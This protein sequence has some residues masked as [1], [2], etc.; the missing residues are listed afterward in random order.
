MLETTTKTTEDNVPE[1]TTNSTQSPAVDASTTQHAE[2]TTK[3]EDNVPEVTTNSTESPAVD[4]STTTEQTGNPVNGPDVGPSNGGRSS[5]ANAFLAI[6]IVIVVI[7]CLIVVVRV[8]QKK[9][10]QKA[11]QQP[12][13]SNISSRSA[14]VNGQNNQDF[15]NPI[16]FP[17]FKYDDDI[18]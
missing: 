12:Q 14:P 10:R 7:I 1:V 2:T 3:T 4:A 18:L 16:S 17:S 9:R 5:A 15:Q 11:Y 8:V 6:F 13:G